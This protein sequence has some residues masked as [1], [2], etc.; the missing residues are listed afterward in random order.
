MS[1]TT[2]TIWTKASF[3]AWGGVSEWRYRDTK[4]LVSRGG[5]GDRFWVIQNEQTGEF[6][7]C[8]IK[9]PSVPTREYAGFVIEALL[10]KEVCKVCGADSSKG[11]CYGCAVVWN[12]LNEIASVNPEALDNFIET[13]KEAKH[14]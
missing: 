14:G 8:D 10:A 2:E 4:Y 7:H 9:G 6:V 3:D 1:K 13:R 11:V 5:E 12:T